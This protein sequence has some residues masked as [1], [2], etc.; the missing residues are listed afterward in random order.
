MSFASG[1]IQKTGGD[2][3]QTGLLE[4]WLF[5]VPK[6]TIGLFTILETVLLTGIKNKRVKMPNLIDFKN[7][8]TLVIYLFAATLSLTAY[9]YNK[10]QAKIREDQSGL[11]AAQV[12]DRELAVKDTEHLAE[13]INKTSDSL[14]GTVNRHYYILRDDVAKIK[15]EQKEM[16]AEQK[17]MAI[18]I[19]TLKAISKR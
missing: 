6:N 5:A 7:T 18:D 8:K 4:D 13:L 9:A 1:S 3:A 2:G 19:A 15:E 11:K 17:S 14:K 12:S 10:D 16:R